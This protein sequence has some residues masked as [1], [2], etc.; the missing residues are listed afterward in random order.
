MSVPELVLNNGVTIPQV[1][2]GVWRVPDDQTQ[3]AVAAALDAGYRHVDTATLSDTARGVGDAVRASGLDRDQVFVTSKVWNDDHGYDATLRAFDASMDRLGFEVLD[4]YLIHWPLARKGTAADTWRAME[5]LYLDGRIR[6][7]GVS[8]FQPEHLRRLLDTAEVVPAV[9]QVELHPYLQQAEVRRTGAELGV[10]TEAWSPIAK[11]GAL[12][13]DPV[14]TGLADKHGVTP[15][16][17]VLR[18]HLQVG[19]VVIPKSVTPERISANID[20][21][22]FELDDQDLAAVAGLD[23]GGRIGP[24]PDQVG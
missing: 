13:A 12:L 11:G 5:R 10:L 18:W 9:N 6:A 3:A 23:R 22:G 20:L 21:F 1:G 24:D 7:I 8:N 4:L 16:Q 15:A 17:A 14:V 19:T 2:F